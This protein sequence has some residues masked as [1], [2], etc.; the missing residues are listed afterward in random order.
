VQDQRERNWQLSCP[1]EQQNHTSGKEGCQCQQHPD[2]FTLRNEAILTCELSK[3]DGN[4][5]VI[6]AH[7]GAEMNPQPWAPPSPQLV[8][9]R[10][11]IKTLN[12]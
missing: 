9:N 2:R 7:C 12:T 3:T 10:P 11:G 5:C 4:D 8:E 1:Y 6:I